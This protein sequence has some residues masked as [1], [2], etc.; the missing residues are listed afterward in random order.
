MLE[1]KIAGENAIII[2]LS[3]QVSEHTIDDIAFFT[4]LLKQELAKKTEELEL[5]ARKNSEEKS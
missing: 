1:I 4:A 5:P 2:Y 3:E